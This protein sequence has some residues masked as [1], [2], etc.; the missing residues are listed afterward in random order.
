MHIWNWNKQKEGQ[1]LAE[2][3]SFFRQSWKLIEG[4][5]PKHTDVIL[6]G[7]SISCSD[8]PMLFM[9]SMLH[10]IDTPEWLYETYFKAKVVDL[11][12]VD[13]P[14]F[15]RNSEP[16]LYPKTANALTAGLGMRETPQDA[17]VSDKS[18]RDLYDTGEFESIKNRAAQEVRNLI[19]ISNR[20]TPYA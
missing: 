12:D 4:K 20:L 7:T 13:V 6:I 14:L 3:Y 8:V 16:V 2:I 17:K 1:T 19:G 15:T 9:K 10:S 5:R 18:V 11:G